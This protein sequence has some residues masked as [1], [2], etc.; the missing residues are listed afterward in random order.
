MNLGTII[1]GLVCI[2]ICTLPF[3]LTSRN[4]KKKEKQLLNALT[5][6]AKQ[7]NSEITK[8]EVNQYFAIGLDESKKTISFLRKARESNKF[9]F[10]DLNSVKK[11]EINNI[12]KTLNNNEKIIDKLNLNLSAFNKKEPNITLEFFNADVSFQLANEYD[13]LERWNTII[14]NIL[15]ETR[16]G[17]VA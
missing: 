1:I 5:D 3:V 9:L 14:N 2:V 17:K 12:N 16:V 7:N 11:C 8:H 15:A 13:S 10:V 4:K 6:F